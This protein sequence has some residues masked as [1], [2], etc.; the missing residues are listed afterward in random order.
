MTAEQDRAPVSSEASHPNSEPGQNAQQPLAS[1]PPDSFWARMKR[2]KVVEWTLV[3]VAFGYALLHGVQMLRETFEWPL[4]IPRLTVI[5]LVLGAPI[6]VTL[7]WYHGQRARHRVS[8]PELSILIALLVVAGS[9]LWWLSR[10]ES[11]RAAATAAVDVT[12]VNPPLADKSIAVLP[13]V[14]MSEKHD[15]EYFSDGLTEE[16]IDRLAGAPDLKVIARTSSFAFKGKNEDVRNIARKLEVANLLEGSVRKAGQSLR[17]TVQLIRAVDGTHLWSHSY[18]EHVADI[19]KVQE[20]IAE[21]VAHALESALTTNSVSSAETPS[22]QAYEAVQKG[23]YFL[24]RSEVGDFDKAIALYEEATRL[25]PKYARAWIAV[26][27]WYHFAGYSGT[28]PVADARSKSLTAVQRALAIDPSGAAAHAV[29]GSIYRDFDWNWRAAKE[30][31]ETAARLDPNGGYEADAGYLNWM[32]T[33]DISGE[34]TSLRRDLVRDPLD[35]GTLWA[36]GISFWAAQRYPESAATYVR[37]LELSPHYS[38]APTLYAQ[39]LLFMGQHEK[40]LA[41]AQSDPDQS[42][43]WSV[44]P[45]IYWKL[46][47]K[48]DSDAALRELEKSATK[49]A[50]N[51]AAMYACRGQTDDVFAWLSRGYRERQ[52]GMQNIKFNPYLLSLRQDRRFQS[53]LVR[54]NLSDGGGAR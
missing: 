5:G 8:G 38:G 52:A 28:L 53:M 47:R 40:A 46:G 34:I 25:D 15:Q 10:T 14:D 32:L 1:E 50:F 26:A 35:T 29:L 27:N 54:M 22:L 51:I 21:K 3:Y 41:A 33:G 17:I 36:L 19:F 43:Q 49:S 12:R 11:T 42:A 16:L 48:A 24:R 18:D 30:E 23:R 45:C 31:F 13:F 37:L 2:H 4:L 20:A 6:A 9:V 44:L 39:A 7:A